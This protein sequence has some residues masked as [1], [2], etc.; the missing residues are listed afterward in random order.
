MTKREW[1]PSG[2]PPAGQSPK[3]VSKKKVNAINTLL[4]EKKWK[5]YTILAIPIAFYLF[6]V[7]SPLLVSGYYSLFNWKGGPN[8]KFIGM[9]NY[10]RLLH[11]KKWLMAVKNNFQAMFI[12]VAGMSGVS[13][14]L[15]LLVTS[16]F[17]GARRVYRFI[18]FLPVIL[19]GVV[20][21]Y[22]F[23]LVLNEYPGLLNALLEM[24]GLGEYA[25]L[26]LGDARYAMNAISLIMVWQGMGLHLVI[27][28]ASLQ[29]ISPDILEASVVDGCTG[30]KQALYITTPMMLGTIRVSLIFSVTS[31]MKMFEYVYIT[32][33][34]SPGGATYVM[35]YYTFMTGFEKLSYFGYACAMCV[36]TIAIS[37][38][39]VGGVNLLMR[40]VE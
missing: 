19:S 33:K 27:Y 39:L 26:W 29:S 35:S 21:G 24:L 1:A 8:M 34:G 37:L 14:L 3:P 20:V 12:G 4:P 6:F 17:V 7:I 11:D 10:L 15:A 16:R 38:V 36:V 22:V 32:T 2:A 5:I 25:R 40:R 28:M 30:L 18:L 31:A 13:Y 23:N 9:G